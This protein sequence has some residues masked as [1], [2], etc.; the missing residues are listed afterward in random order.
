MQLGRWGGKDTPEKNAIF[1]KYNFKNA[2][3]LQI[4]I[5]FK[6]LELDY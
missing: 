2:Q 5:A 4:W 1:N 3:N 6:Y